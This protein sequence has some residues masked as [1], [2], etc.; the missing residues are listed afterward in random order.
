MV[1]MGEKPKCSYKSETR[2]Y[3]VES[4][5]NLQRSEI[6]CLCYIRDDLVIPT[7]LKALNFEP[8]LCS[9]L[10]DIDTKLGI[11]SKLENVILPIITILFDVL[12]KCKK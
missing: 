5:K 9:K 6:E 7:V 8:D 12:Y 10:Q 3:N 2:F 4:L 11:L 1:L